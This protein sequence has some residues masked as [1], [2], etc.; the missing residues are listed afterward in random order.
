MTDGRSRYDVD[1]VR[2]RTDLVAL[3]GQHVTL[4]KRGGRHIG[5]CPFHQE[6]TPSFGVDEQ[7]GFW[8]CFGCGKGGDAFTFL[9]QL[10]R[11]SFPEAVERLAERAGI[12]P[13][14]TF[15]APQRKEERDFLYEA[16]AAAAA[17]FA[18]ALRG[19][20]GT[21]ARQ[22]L[23]ARGIT[24]DVAARF[25]LGYAPQRWDA[26]ESHLRKRGFSTEVLAKAGLILARS[27]GEGYIDRFRHRLMIP[28]Y[29]RRGRVVAFGG[30][31]L[32]AEDN[33]KY[34][35]TA[36]TPIFHKSRTLYA[37]HLAAETIGKRGRVI[38]T[39]GYFDVIACHLAG[40]TEAVA[41]LGTALG[42]EHVQILRRLAER[43]YLVYDADSA[44]IN[45][46]LRSQALFRQAE[47]EVRIVCLP[48]GHDPDTLLRNEGAAVFE[49]CLE[50]SLAPVE[51]ELQR[52]VQ[53]HPA[54][55]AE[56]RLHLFRAA[57][58]VLQPLSKLERAEY[59][60][61]LIDRALGS[62]G[63]LT[64]LQQ[65]LLG[66]VAALDRSAQ[67]GSTRRPTEVAGANQAASTADAQLERELL[68]AV[69]QHPDFAVRAAAAL[70]PEVFNHAGYRA[71]FEAICAQI[72]QGQAPDAR[73]IVAEDELT[74]AL[75]AA[76]AVR[77][78]LPLNQT[79]LDG[80]LERLRDEY[81][82]RQAQPQ[83][84]DLTDRA[85]VEAF[86]AKLRERSQRF[87]LRQYGTEE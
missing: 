38:I 26:L 18:V 12:Q 51:F 83:A 77:D 10:E 13:V 40:F 62:R 82:R 44:G 60:L 27:H 31:A 64:E 36:E 74:A 65:A 34:L 67:R 59:A 7:K 20:T 35:N 4:K 28:I 30:R 78:M 48:A 85:A 49:R 68:T 61:R 42:E 32:S 29:D 11:L 16:N 6:K 87:A 81:D 8:H 5:L 71:I 69:V 80:L 47:V 15:E 14:E 55:D 75:I 79:A 63:D 56:G 73:R 41:S 58:K 53:Q 52:L 21:V 43:V 70:T 45:A 19:N 3:I 54:R 84:L 50:E 22:Y 1:Q 9:M 39:E 57:A 46:A 17:A 2:E 25:G 86:T 66:E 72:A 37:L 23:E 33:P 76:L 24:P